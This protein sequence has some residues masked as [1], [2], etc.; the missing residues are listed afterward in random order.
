MVEAD[1]AEANAVAE[2]I[3]SLANEKKN[4]LS[5]KI[6]IGVELERLKS[7][8]DIDP[9][10]MKDLAGKGINII[11]FEMPKS[12]YRDF[13]ENIKTIR[14]EETKTSVKFLIAELG[15]KEEREVINSINNYRVEM[16]QVSTTELKQKVDELNNHIDALD[17]NLHVFC[18]KPMSDNLA[19][20]VKMLNR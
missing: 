19:D 12:E 2:K 18:E 7:W 14:L 9:H 4:Y 10:S 8:G 5:E 3:V 20:C 1:V 11:L 15:T 13:G 17:A 6:A 16:P